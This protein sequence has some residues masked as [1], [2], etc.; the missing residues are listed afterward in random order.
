MNTF[1]AALHQ[2]FLNMLNLFE[3]DECDFPVPF[4]RQIYWILRELFRKAANSH[5][6]I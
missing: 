1:L 2:N 6:L 3:D 5:L 4:G